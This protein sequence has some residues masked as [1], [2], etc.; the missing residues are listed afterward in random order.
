MRSENFRPWFCQREIRP[1]VL[2]D[3][4]GR[5][6]EQSPSSEHVR[7]GAMRVHPFEGVVLVLQGGG[8]LRRACSGRRLP[9][10]SVEPDIEVH[11]LCG[12][13]I[14]AINGALI[15]GNPPEKRVRER[16][17]EF[18]EAITNLPIRFTD[19][20]LLS[21]MPWVAKGHARYWTNRMGALATMLY[22]VP[23]FSFRLGPFRPVNSA[24]ESPDLASYYDTGPLK[25]TLARLVN[26]DLINSRPMRLSVAA[27]NVQTGSAVYFENSKQRITVDHVVASASLP[28]GFPP[29]KIGGEWYWDG[30]VVSNSPMQ[31]VVDNRRRESAL[32]F[33][34]DLWDA[35]GEVPLDIPSANLRAMEIHSASRVNV[36]LEQYKKMQRF[37]H[38]LSRFLEQLPERCQDDPEVRFLSEEAHARVA[39]I[40]Q[41]KYQS[42]KYET[43]GKTL[44]S[45]AAAR[46]KKL[47]SRI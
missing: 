38:A 14:G 27:T 26:F 28:P 12:T 21:Y 4:G 39:T 45:P 29:T 5:V 30:G 15:V 6:H 22:G 37:R 33:Q 7:K 24:A 43:A 16:L 34:V 40:V 18:W 42:K 25:E 46:W 2:L 8:A 9:S 11:W 31:S 23:G 19:V 47:A 44:N 41:L 20:P 17:R 1:F 32:A 3:G 36:S 10:D 13:S 35:N